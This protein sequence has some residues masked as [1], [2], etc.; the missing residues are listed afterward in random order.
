LHAL[1]EERA[2]NSKNAIN[3]A[4]QQKGNRKKLDLSS[5][6]AEVR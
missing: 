1:K 3:L 4:K 5:Q 6:A 2:V